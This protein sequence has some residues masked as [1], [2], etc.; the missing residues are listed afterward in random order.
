MVQYVLSRQACVVVWKLSI[1]PD[2]LQNPVLPDCVAIPSLYDLLDSV[3]YVTVTFAL[4]T[5]M[6]FLFLSAL[7]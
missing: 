1:L 7:V 2:S 6:F 4:R 5:K 3:E